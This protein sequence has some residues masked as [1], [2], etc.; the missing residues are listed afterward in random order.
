MQAKNKTAA[1][2]FDKG[3]S[4]RYMIL[5]NRLI[6]NQMGSHSVAEALMRRLD[7]GE[8][9]FISTD[10]DPLTQ[11]DYNNKLRK[12][13]SYN[14]KIYGPIRQIKNAKPGPGPLAPAQLGLDYLRRKSADFRVS[15]TN[16][17]FPAE[18]A[19][20]NDKKNTLFIRLN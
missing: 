14:I 5:E 6:R 16:V 9:S 8:V 18:M 7:L 4:Y 12:Q 10:L 19:N 17:K 11:I 2:L 3:E 20:E 13:A 1:L 15:V